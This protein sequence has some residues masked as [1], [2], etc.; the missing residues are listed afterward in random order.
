MLS[1]GFEP[2]P[3]RSRQLYSKT[4]PCPSGLALHI[5]C[6]CA[7]VCL[8]LCPV[9]F[10]LFQSLYLSHVFIIQFRNQSSLC[11]FV[12]VLSYVLCVCI[13]VICKQSLDQLGH[14]DGNKYSSFA[15]FKQTID[16]SLNVLFFLIFLNDNAPCPP[17]AIPPPPP[18]FNFLNIHRRKIKRKLCRI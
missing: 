18:I 14:W 15:L 16:A 5:M 3:F 11:N 6:L 4:I 2:I 8:R 13:C 12:Y 9:T 10:I 7:S 17:F 1:V